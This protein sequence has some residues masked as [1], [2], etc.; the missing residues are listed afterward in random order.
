MS[1]YQQY[2]DYYYKCNKY[3]GDKGEP[4]HYRGFKDWLVNME[5]WSWKIILQSSW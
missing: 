5:C 4:F 1:F 2:G 3:M